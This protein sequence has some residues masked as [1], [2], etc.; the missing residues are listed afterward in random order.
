MFC[1][2]CGKQQ[3]SD[4][5]RFCSGC[6][7]QLNV[8]KMLLAEE[9]ASLSKTSE[10]ITANRSRRKRDMTIGAAL[11]CVFALHTAWT[12]EDLSLEREYTSLILKCLILFA[13]INIVPVIS[14]F[15]FGSTRQDSTSLPKILSGF[16]AKLKKRNQTSVLSA[17]YGRPAADYFTEVINTSELVPP[18]SITEDTTKLLRNNPN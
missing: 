16:I 15:F 14:D 7:L 11:M 13:L 8:V 10:S 18:P 9:D 17:G 12:T 4:D 3:I 6:G 5:V 2:K 1:S